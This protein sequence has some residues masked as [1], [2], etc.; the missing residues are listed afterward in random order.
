MDARTWDD[1]RIDRCRMHVIRPDGEL[2]SFCRYYFGD[3]AARPTE[4]VQSS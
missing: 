3:R 2:D 1:D 4:T